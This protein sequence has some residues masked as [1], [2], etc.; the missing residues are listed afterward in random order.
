VEAGLKLQRTDVD[1]EQEYL[2]QYTTD[3]DSIIGKSFDGN[4]AKKVEV[5]CIAIT[6]TNVSAHVILSGWEETTGDDP[7][8]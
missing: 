6:G 8:I 4:A 3:R 7:T 1:V 5:E 2:N